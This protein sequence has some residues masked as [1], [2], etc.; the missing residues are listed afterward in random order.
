LPFPCVVIRVGHL[1]CRSSHG[2]TLVELLVVLVVLSIA[3]SIVIPSLGNSYD[4]WVLRSNSR[5][6]VALFRFASDT[7]RRNGSD[8]AGYYDDHRLVLLRNGT[9]LREIEI[10]ASVIVSP[11][12]P[13]GAVFLSTGQIVSSQQFVLENNRGRRASITFGPLPG[14]VGLVEGIQ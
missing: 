6:A 9:I 1:R 2:V 10:P 8:I 11:K 4:T 13:R 3:L 14:Q 7:A 5:K 12:K